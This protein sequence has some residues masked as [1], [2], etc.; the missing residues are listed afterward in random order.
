MSKAELANGGYNTS[1]A[2][3]T[4]DT[5]RRGS[6]PFGKEYGDD[7]LPEA[8]RRLNSVDS[9]AEDVLAAMG[10][11]QE[12]VRNRSTLSVTFMSFVLA[13]VPYGLSTTLIYPLTNGGPS[14][15][16]WGWCLVCLLMLAVAISLAEITSVSLWNVQ[17]LEI[18]ARNLIVVTKLLNRFSQLLVVSTTRHLCFPLAGAAN[19][20]HG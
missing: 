3:T 7:T 5:Y 4:E 2:P 20:L 14:T 18:A 16:I 8:P 15:V 9:A 12:L 11:T 1:Y 6:K 13:S 19:L 17:L 10:Y